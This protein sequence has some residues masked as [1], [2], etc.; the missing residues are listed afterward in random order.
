MQLEKKFIPD[1]ILVQNCAK[2]IPDVTFAPHFMSHGYISTSKTI[3]SKTRHCL[4]ICM[5]TVHLCF[6]NVEKGA[7]HQHALD[8]ERDCVHQVSPTCV[9][10]VLTDDECDVDSR[11]DDACLTHTL[12]YGS[13]LYISEGKVQMRRLGGGGERLS[14]ADARSTKNRSAVGSASCILNAPQ[15][16]ALRIRSKFPHPVWPGQQR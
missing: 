9:C 2:L 6:V 10:T 4:C 15:S 12:M 16:A 11:M 7:A 5:Q 14:Q 3:L 1:V 13:V 8:G